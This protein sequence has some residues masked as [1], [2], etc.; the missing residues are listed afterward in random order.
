MHPSIIRIVL[1][2]LLM[3]SC[4]IKAAVQVDT[5]IPVQLPE[6]SGSW[7]AMEQ[8]RLSRITNQIIIL[9]N[10]HVRQDSLLVISEN[11]LAVCHSLLNDKDQLIHNQTRQLENLKAIILQK[12]IQ[13]DLKEQAFEQSNRL[14][15]DLHKDL[16][17][18]RR[19]KTVLWGGVALAGAV[20]ASFFIILK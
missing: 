15:K 17:K 7:V 5:L 12:D 19:A 8:D 10:E 14:A 13:L 3:S 1:L 18:A 4:P 6:F 2:W 20:L 16:R 9:Q 11:S